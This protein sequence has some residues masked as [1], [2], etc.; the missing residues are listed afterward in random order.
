M[1]HN[2]IRPRRQPFEVA[3]LLAAP[4]CG[5]FLILLDVRPQSV[6][7]AMPPPLQTGWETGLIVGG[8]VGLSGI[9]WPGR[10]STGLGIE[11]AALLMLGSITGMYAVAIAA[12]SGTR[13]VAA[14]SF[15][16][17]VSAG[18]FWRSA[19]IVLDLRQLA[20]AS[21]EI[22]TDVVTGESA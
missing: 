1:P 19:Q 11:L 7:L 9:L 2:R 15:V 8:L 16:V 21:R 12:I 20:Q 4:P 14:I 17:A 10:L 6:T 22:G 13:G 18:S 5:V 3:V